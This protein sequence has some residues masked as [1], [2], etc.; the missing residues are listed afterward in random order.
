MK[1]KISFSL[2]FI[3]ALG[4]M[5][6][7][8]YPIVKERY[9]NT[10]NNIG[11]EIQ[12]QNDSISNNDHEVNISDTGNEQA[13]SDLES[14]NLNEETKTEIDEKGVS[15]NIAAEDCD[16]ECEN[17]KDNA[18]DLKYC[19]NICD[20]SPIKDSENCESKSG[21]DKDYCYKNQAVAKTDL[22]IC[23]SISDSKIK[24]SCRSRVT[25]DM[26]ENQ[27]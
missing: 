20:L 22:N 13:D 6:Y 5:S 21:T 9:F 16:N 1:F 3:V 4:V 17:F 8:S 18:S 11:K 14:Q 2:I 10:E 27:L 24:S 23:G 7:F 19:Q 15:A 12:E 25:E 26:L